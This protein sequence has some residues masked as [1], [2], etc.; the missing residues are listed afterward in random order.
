MMVISYP[1]ETFETYLHLHIPLQIIILHLFIYYALIYPQ[2]FQ[3][4][5]FTKVRLQLPF[6]KIVFSADFLNLVYGNV[7]TLSRNVIRFSEKGPTKAERDN[8]AT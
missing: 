7:A 4:I 6:I 8:P 1:R 3:C 2:W 5:F